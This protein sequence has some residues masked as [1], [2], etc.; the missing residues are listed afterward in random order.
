M[1]ELGNA[2]KNLLVSKKEQN[3]YYDEN[4]KIDINDTNNTHAIIAKRVKERNVC[5]DIGCG[6]GYTGE[7]LEQKECTVYGIDMDE[8]ALEISRTKKCYRK[9]YDFS[10]TEENDPEYKSFF[11]TPV[12]FDYIILADVLEHVIDPG[13]IL[14]QFSRKLKA[15]GKFLISVPNVAHI[16]VTLNLMNRTFNYNKIG[17]LDNTHLRF[18]TKS[19]FFDMINAINEV[20]GLS[21]QAT[22]IGKTISKPPYLETYSKLYELLNADDESC[23]LQYVYEIKN[24]NT[25]KEVPNN[26]LEKKDY[27]QVLEE[28]LKEVEKLQ[29][30]VKKYE[31]ENSLLIK[32]KQ[33]LS[34]KNIIYLKQLEAEK[35]QYSKVIESHSWKVTKPLRQLRAFFIRKKRHRKA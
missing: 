2:E 22:L 19:S 32:E 33:D 31:K 18:F 4:I 10:I 25:K 24:A 9:I 26:L 5:L 34:D 29:E 8:K 27:S 30:Q 7:L 17:L 12:K 11:S 35:E 21:L 16:D 15:N 23:V 3:K 20:Y 6:A 1:F 14:Y 28:K 13:K